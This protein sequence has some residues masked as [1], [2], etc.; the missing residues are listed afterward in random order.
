ML[1]SQK[2]KK[3]TGYRMFSYLGDGIQKT[4]TKS[5]CFPVPVLHLFS[6]FSSL[7]PKL[8]NSPN[9]RRHFVRRIWS[10]SWNPRAEILVRSLER[11]AQ[12]DDYSV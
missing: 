2:K 8:L 3:V 7:D 6:F 5:Q 4:K 9:Q 1:I 11:L 12:L 10:V